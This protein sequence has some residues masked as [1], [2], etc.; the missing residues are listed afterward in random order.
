MILVELIGYIARM[1]SA[2]EGPNYKRGPYIIQAL[3]LLLGPA[4]FAASIYMILGRIILLTAGEAHAPIRRRWLTKIFVTGDVISFLAQAAGMYILPVPLSGRNILL[5][6]AVLGGAILA[7]ASSSGSAS[8]AGMGQ[9]IIVAGLFVQIIFFGIFISTSVLFHARINEVPTQLSSQPD[10][11]WRKHIWVLY[12]AN[13]LIMVRSI[14]RVVEYIQGK[15]G[16][17]QSK[18]LFLYIF[19][20]ALMVI[21]MVIMNVVHPSQ[22]SGWLKAC[23]GTGTGVDSEMQ[24]FAAGERSRREARR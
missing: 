2:K 23:K 19:D 3:L 1:M 18:E 15:E 16:Y 8:A 22:I 6:L 7:G 13:A 17:L 11:N 14:Y 24:N 12:A 21:V 20:A 9:K 4:F 5:T 10:I